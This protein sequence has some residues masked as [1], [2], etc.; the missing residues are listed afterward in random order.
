VLS[1]ATLLAS[2]VA[3]T[4]GG[5]REQRVTGGS[6]TSTIDARWTIVAHKGT[7]GFETLA[8]SSSG[9]RLDAG[10]IP[11]EGAIGITVTESPASAV[12][13]PTREASG[14]LSP[15][16]AA[17]HA[18]A[19]AENAIELM[20]R[21]VRT[22]A[23]AV[24]VE[25]SEPARFRTLAGVGA[26]EESYEYLYS[27]H[28]NVQVDVVARRGAEIYFIELD[29]ELAQLAAGESAFTRLLRAWR[30]K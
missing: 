16:A 19:R 7:R 27:G 26:A 4:S 8:L 18:V 23:G 11:P 9:A 29:T 21:V 12:A 5:E 24:G 3:S 22:P 1:V 30:W 15:Q 28:G 20:S 2:G 14:E 6:F 17:A 10:G 13:P 25:A